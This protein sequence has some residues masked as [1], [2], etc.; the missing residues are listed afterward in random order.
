MLPW[1][2]SQF[3]LFKAMWLILV[4]GQNEYLWLGAALL[5]LQ[6]I[7][8][9]SKKVDFMIMPMAMVGIVIDVILIFIGLFI[10]EQTPYWLFLLWAGFA[11][12]IGHSLQILNK[13]PT[14]W[15]V[16]VGGL[17]GSGSYMTGWHFEA[18]QLPYGPAISSAVLFAI[19]ALL[20]PFLMFID[21]KVRNLA[22]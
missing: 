19:W 5:A 6:V 1:L 13:L 22:C 11:L 21:Q 17:A 14:A 9:P 12:S 8:S 10:F 2:V 3:L 15:L 16:I 18:V 4:I 20:L 7:I